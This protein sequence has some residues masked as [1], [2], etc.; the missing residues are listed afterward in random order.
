[1]AAEIVQLYNSLIGRHL[2]SIF[3]GFFRSTNTK[4]DHYKDFGYPEVLDFDKL[5]AVY[6][7]NGLANSAVERTLSKTWQG[8]AFLLETERDGTQRPSDDKETALEKEIR[9]HF[10]KLRFWQRIADLDRRA[11]VGGFSGLILRFADG[12]PWDQPV[13]FVS[14]LKGLVG[15]DPI[16]AKQL[17]VSEWHQNELEPETYGKP[18][19]FEFTETPIDPTEADKK[20]LQR[21]V[22]IHADRLFIWSQDGTILGDSLLQ[23]GYNDL[24]DLEKIKGA[25]GEG[26]WKNA[27]AAPV[28]ETGDSTVT[29]ADMAKAMGTTVEDL[30]KKMNDQVNNYN[31]GFDQMLMLQGMTAKALP[32]T[33]PS[34]EH[35]WSA[36]LQS[37]AASI[38]MPLKI[39]VGNQTGERASTEDANEWGETIMARRQNYTHPRLY[40]LVEHLMAKRVLPADK[41]WHLEQSDLTE[42]NPAEKIE[43]ASKMT[44]INQSSVTADSTLTFT[45]E[46]IRKVAGYEPLSPSELDVEPEPEDDPAK[47]KPKPKGQA[48]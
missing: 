15:I 33:L 38:Q 35:F 19:V 28:F 10:R 43:R 27:R 21:T 24:I 2:S 14:G 29:F 31:K 32:I 4:H 3:P 41:D 34:P 16:W 6:K 11:M 18:K 20:P 46:E 26:F 47:T 23:P 37:F 30:H 9:L 17:R 22:Q 5:Y 8:N 40:E 44:T 42:A 45:V 48:K 1:M 12:K 39:L 25:G 13:D 7:R 36:P